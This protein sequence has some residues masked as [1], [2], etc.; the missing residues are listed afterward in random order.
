M[1]ILTYTPKDG[2]EPTSYEFVFEDLTFPQVV[3]LEH[4]TK[5]NWGDIRSLYWADNFE[6]QG[7]LLLVLMHAE[8]PELTMEQL[9]LRPGQITFDM[10]KAEID[11]FTARLLAMPSLTDAQRNSLKALGVDPSADAP[12]EVAEDPKA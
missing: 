8:E 3:E 6:V 9:D 10:S 12:A 1:P 11:A 2:G 4:L 7:Y 5:R